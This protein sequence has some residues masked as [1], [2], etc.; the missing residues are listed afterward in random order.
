MKIVTNENGDRDLIITLT[1]HISP[2]GGLSVAYEDALYHVEQSIADAFFASLLGAAKK[3]DPDYFDPD[4]V[5][6]ESYGAL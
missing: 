1:A 6:A 4:Y 3:L 5:S 2:H